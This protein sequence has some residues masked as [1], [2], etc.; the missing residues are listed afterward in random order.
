MHIGRVLA[1]GAALTLAAGACSSSSKTVGGNGA[2]SS[3]P[4]KIGYITSAT[5]IAAPNFADGQ[6][7]A[8][9]AIDAANAA[10]G[11][12]GHQLELVGEDDQSNPSLDKTEAQDLV[13]K[14]VFGV[15]MFSPFAFEA[16]PYLHQ[17]G[18]PVTGEEFDGPEWGEQPYTNMFSFTV[19]EDSPING[20][21]YTSLGAANWLKSIG[22]KRLASLTYHVPSSMQAVL[23]LSGPAKTIGVAD[24]YDNLNV[25][26]GGTDFTADILQIKSN[27]C[28]AVQSPVQTQS[29]VAIAE[30]LKQ[31]GLNLTQIYYTGYSQD[32]LNNPTALA[33][34]NGA[35]FET[36]VNFTDQNSGT[37][38]MMANIA[39]YD[40]K[41]H[42]GDIPDIGLYGSYMSAQIMIDGLKFAGKPDRTA[43]ITAMHKQTNYNVGGIQLGG[44]DFAAFATP[45]MFGG[46]G[47]SWIIQLQGDHFV[48][49]NGGKPSCGGRVEAPA[50]PS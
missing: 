28:D 45:D 16:A 6:P 9:A 33:A 17:Q 19:P 44:V 1:V 40:P 31:A 38:T 15:I 2:T 27:H 7:G 47:C 50:P 36:A 21:Y 14:G 3:A 30:G 29:V 4:I 22:V 49:A 42:A 24:C 43:F 26:Y 41:Y 23:D 13:S 46:N 25:P 34:M 35:Y 10:G 8:Q 18:L 5:G 20:K 37:K 12:D 39:K 48:T 11:V 32:V